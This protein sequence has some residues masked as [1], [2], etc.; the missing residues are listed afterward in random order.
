MQALLFTSYKPHSACQASRVGLSGP[1]A[2]CGPFAPSLRA[3]MPL[4]EGVGGDINAEAYADEVLQ[5][6]VQ[7]VTF[8]S[9][10]AFPTRRATR[11]SVAV[12]IPA[13]SCCLTEAPFSGMIASAPVVT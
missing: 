3:R 13:C 5:K 11:R 8:L 9:R 7:S 12:T 4:C 2:G 6:G 1:P 10:F